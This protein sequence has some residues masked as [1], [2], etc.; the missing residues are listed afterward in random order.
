ML[1]RRPAFG[2]ISGICGS[3]ARK[4]ER[5]GEAAIGCL[6][7]GRK[8]A[9]FIEAGTKSHGRADCIGRF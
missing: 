6:L 3:R 8:R 5:E 9:R 7:A 1:R 2:L 4:G